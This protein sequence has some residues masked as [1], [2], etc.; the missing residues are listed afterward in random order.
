M[1]DAR[2]H[3]HKGDFILC[4]MPCI[5]L[6]RQKCSDRNRKHLIHLQS[7]NGVYRYCIQ[8]VQYTIFCLLCVG[9]EFAG[10]ENDGPNPQKMS[11]VLLLQ[12]D[13]F[14]NCHAVITEQ[15]TDKILCTV[16][17]ECSSCESS[18]CP[19]TNN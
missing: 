6:D 14:I 7:N 12:H 3:G 11:Y 1:S 10:S 13:D 5:A 8:T 18:Y 15:R 9:A 16:H 19:V 4:P 17:F 2:T